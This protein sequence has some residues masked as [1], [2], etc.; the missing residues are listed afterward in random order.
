MTNE[1]L[2]KISNR[3][4]QTVVTDVLMATAAIALL[5]FLVA[6]LS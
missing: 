1:R 4:R 5:L 2:D 6:V 3:Q